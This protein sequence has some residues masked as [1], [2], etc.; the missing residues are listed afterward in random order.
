[1]AR[2]I[3]GLARKNMGRGRW[4]PALTHRAAFVINGIVAA[5]R[6]SN[7]TAA[8]GGAP[9]SLLMPDV[10]RLPVLIAVPH[11]GRAYSA[12]LLSAMRK[13]DETA[14]RLEDRLA[15][16]LAHDV[17]TQTGAAL[18][19]AHA[20]RALI[21]LN[22]SP[23][24]V[25]WG[26]ITGPGTGPGTAFAN[27]RA[28][29]GLGLIPRRLAGVGEIWRGPLPAAE[30]EGR[31]AEVHEPYHL[32]LAGALDRIRARWGAALL[33]DL[34]SMPPLVARR[35][36]PAAEFVLGD[37]FGASCAD[38]LVDAGLA[39]LAAQGRVAALNR[40]YAG[41]YVLDRHGCPRRG[42]HALQLE[43]CRSTYLDRQL[44]E[45]SARFP[46]VV[47]LIAG[48]V[49]MLADETARLGAGGRLPLTAE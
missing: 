21:D 19:V 5:D 29:S 37:R 46:A 30:L 12:A 35:D 38:T 16:R 25:D 41:G 3:D 24:D 9:F 31:L 32:A 40:P 47:R 49:R 26:M 39:Y 23:D 33:V 1:M 17:A 6:H 20:P 48:L 10:V 44:A 4:C 27:R 11:A 18:L 43:I 34:H 45:P 8:S 42:T 7:A 36:E 28:R 2:L 14:I 15:D 22:R 13:A